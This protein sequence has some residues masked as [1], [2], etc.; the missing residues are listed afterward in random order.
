MDFLK[1]IEDNSILIIPNNIK[2]KIL[3]YIDK[4]NLLLNIKYMTFNDLKHGLLYS[5]DN[6]TIYNLMNKYNLSYSI[7]KD[8]IRNTYY[9]TEDNYTNDKL[10]YLLEIKNYLNDNNLLIKDE[11]FI[12][13]LKS[14]SKLYVYGFDKEISKFNK[15]LLKLASEYITVEDIIYKDIKDYKHLVYKASTM[16]DEVTYVAEEISNLIKDGIPLNKIYIT[17]LNE[18]YNFTLRRV[19]KAYG[20]P[21]FIKNENILYDTAI[22]KYFFNNLSND[23][24]KLFDDIKKKYD[25]DNNMSNNI[26]YNKL[27]SLS[28]KYYWEE[29]KLKIKD[30]MIEEAMNTTL[31]SIHMEDEIITTDL[32]DNLFDDDEYVFLMNFNQGIFPK[33]KKDEDYINDDIK[34]K[35]L[36]ETTN[37]LN[38][39]YKDKLL[40]IIKS[41]KNL[42]ITYKLHSAFDSYLPS[43]LVKE[44]FKEEV[45]KDF[46]SNYSNDTN[47]IS[48]GKKIDNLVK[49]KIND[50]LLPILNN[51][52]KIKY[53]EYD[54]SFTKLNVNIE[55][56]TFSYSSMSNYFKCPFRYYC[57]N[58][59]YLDE[60]NK[61][62]DTYIG[63]LFHHVLE[64]YMKD[65]DHGI[66]SNIDKLYDDYVKE[67][68][69]LPEDDWNKYIRNNSEKYFT[70]KLRKEIHTIIQIIDEQYQLLDSS[71]TQEQEKEIQLK[72]IDD[73]KMNTKINTII[74]GF[75]DKCIFIGND[76][77][78]IDY[79][80][81]KSD[82]ID[83][84][85]FEY[86][87]H[88][89]LPIY[90]YLLEAE[91]PKLNVAGI[92]L[93]KILTG[94]NNKVKNKT[95]YEL[96]QKELRLDGIY[97]PDY[98]SKISNGTPKDI[99]TASASREYDKD[100]KEAIKN[101]IKELITKCVNEVYDANFEIKPI[102]I[103]D[104]KEDGCQFCHFRDVC[105]MTEEN[106]NYIYT[107]DDKGDDDNE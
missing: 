2:D 105:Y 24:D 36:L 31:P 1:T 68:E 107:K 61:S 59:L 102:N 67:I 92:Y 23:L 95:Q 75:V 73:L 69:D 80:T 88:I 74:K 77:F 30:I 79:K 106:Y 10:N 89:Q 29:D 37:E 93:Q 35:E 53:D 42:T 26:V 62:F 27:F 98:T 84:K 101:N 8:F 57:N 72:T 87:L 11:L 19:F 65:K 99:M 54:N 12:D 47:K 78:V 21:Y 6:R 33:I 22:A 94:N 103:N 7:A 81:G 28:N 96:R 4:N 104:K 17:G 5:Y 3:D 44:Y 100:E 16:E 9:I 18:E 41:I 64:V 48:F 40:N 51:N 70:E 45:I 39:Q 15:Y 55:P 56:K 97:N 20:I 25:I 83:R 52:Y 14:K 85:A 58:V 91:N 50:D 49:Y 76:V 60:F 32:Y 71:Y 43:Y 66:T 90:M 34:P 82:I 46:I 86:G 38:I 63:S 13:L